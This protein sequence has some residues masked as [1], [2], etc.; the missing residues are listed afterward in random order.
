M[1]EVSVLCIKGSFVGFKYG[2]IIC[3]GYVCYYINCLCLCLLK[4]KSIVVCLRVYYY[5]M[6]LVWWSDE[7]FF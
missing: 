5:L 6:E 7:V 1:V 4:I 2:L 3:Y